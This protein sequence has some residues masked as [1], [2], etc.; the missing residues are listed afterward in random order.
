M[1]INTLIGQTL[2]GYE[3]SSDKERL[4]LKTKDKSYRMWHRQDCCESVY[5]EDISGDLDDLLHSPILQAEESTNDDNRPANADCS[6][7]WT[8][9]R[10]ST[11]KGQVVLRWLGQSNGYYGEGVDFD[12][13]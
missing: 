4:T 3:V 11:T 5:L 9:Y 10:L 7:T 8:F 2:I 13:V 6:F 12:E 1:N